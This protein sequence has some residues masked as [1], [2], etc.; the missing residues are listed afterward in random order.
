MRDQGKFRN[1]PVEDSAM[2]RDSDGLLVPQYE[3]DRML[4]DF[5]GEYDPLSIQLLFSIRAV[6]RRINE[7]AS[8]WLAPF[9]LTA[10]QYNYLAVLYA[11]RDKGMSPSKIAAI[12]HTVGGTVTSMISALERQKLIRRSAH[13][14]D[15]RSAVIRLTARGERLF[16]EAART[17]HAQIAAIVGTLKAG[18]AQSLLQGVLDL[19]TAIRKH[20]SALDSAEAA[21]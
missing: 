21:V 7:A 18:E 10:T 20:S 16:H 3:I 2:D 19:G 13:Q 12:V 5:A 14:T 4:R 9:G 1:C 11:N 15:R 8:N 6:G 17:H